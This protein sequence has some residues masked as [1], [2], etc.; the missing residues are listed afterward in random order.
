VILGFAATASP[1]SCVPGRAQVGA[2]LGRRVSGTGRERCLCCRTG[3]VHADVL[4]VVVV[5]LEPSVDVDEE[6][7]ELSGAGGDVDIVTGAEPEQ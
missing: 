1:R 6:A 3:G 2:I 7:G 4:A 5:E